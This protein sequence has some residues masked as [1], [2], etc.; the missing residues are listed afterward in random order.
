MKGVNALP[1]FF[2]NGEKSGH[3]RYSIE[4][5]DGGR[6]HIGEAERIEA[7][8]AEIG[9]VTGV[10]E[11]AVQVGGKWSGWFGVLLL[12][13]GVGKNL[14][15]DEIENFA[16]EVRAICA[17]PHGTAV[18]VLIDEAAIHEVGRNA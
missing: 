14:A 13:S 3:V 4:F 11:V 8:A 1:G 10:E 9:V 16:I 15:R 5:L 17:A 6:V 18:D 2:A 12:E 7:S